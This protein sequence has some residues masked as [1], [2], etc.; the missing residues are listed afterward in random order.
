MKVVA[1]G[2]SALRN[3]KNAPQRIKVEKLLYSESD[4]R[5]TSMQKTTG[6][7][8]AVLAKLIAD[9]RAGPG[10]FPPEIALDPKIVLEALKKDFNIY[11]RTT[12]LK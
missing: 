1:T 11:E 3:K 9:G 10:A 7:T 12:P 4:D 2:T 6:F 5:W 8:T